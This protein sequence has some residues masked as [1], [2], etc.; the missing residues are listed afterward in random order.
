MKEKEKKGLLERLA[1]FWLQGAPQTD[2]GGRRL[3]RGIGKIN[4]AFKT[5][6]MPENVFPFM[7]KEG[8]RTFSLRRAFAEEQE[9]IRQAERRFLSVSGLRETENTIL[10]GNDATARGEHWQTREGL[11]PEESKLLRGKETSE[12]LPFWVERKET[13]NDMPDMARMFFWEGP[14]GG[15]QKRQTLP[16][17]DDR[18]PKRDPAH[19]DDTSGR[20]K[21]EKAQDEE[22]VFWSKEEPAAERTQA[23]LPDID[24]L[25]REMTR[26]LWEEREGCCRRLGG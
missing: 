17:A 1:A 24:G 18:T 20:R 15:R 9:D 3:W 6:E 23:A 22:T 13:A 14:E 25:M 21:P 26:R 11:F 2:G 5:K 7:E 12:T 4:K 10:A 19:E 8:T 16:L